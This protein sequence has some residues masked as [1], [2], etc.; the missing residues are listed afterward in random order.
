MHSKT[1]IHQIQPL[2]FEGF[3][4]LVSSVKKTLIYHLYIYISPVGWLTC[5]LPP[6]RGN[7]KQPNDFRDCVRYNFTTSIPPF[8]PRLIDPPGSG[9]GIHQTLPW[10][11]NN[12][13]FQNVFHHNLLTEFF[14][15]KN[16]WHIDIMG[17]CFC[18]V[19]VLIF[20]CENKSTNN[21]H[22]FCFFCLSLKLE[23]LSTSIPRT[24]ELTHLSSRNDCTELH[25]W[26]LTW[27][28]TNPYA[29]SEIHLQMVD[30]PLSC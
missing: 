29:Q 24:W 4:L 10:K 15:Q 6:F 8:P 26:K 20:F 7:Q 27:H 18:W 19:S 3:W 17:M 9:G 5:Y 30:V 23:K 28:W 11:K 25:P 1:Q 2:I 21:H 12:I 14:Q 13:R 16:N 22:V